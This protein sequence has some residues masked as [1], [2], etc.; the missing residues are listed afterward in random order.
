V[1]CDNGEWHRTR[2]ITTPQGAGGVPCPDTNETEICAMEA[3]P[4]PQD[5]LHSEWSAWSPC[6]LTCGLGQQV[7][8][9]EVRVEAANG[10]SPCGALMQEQSC[11]DRACPVDCQ[12]SSWSNWTAC[13]KSC[14]DGAIK[15]RHRYVVTNHEYNGVQ[16]SHEQDVSTCA[17]EAC[18][19][20]CIMS[21]FGDRSDCS[22]TCGDG[23]QTSS[24]ETLLNASYGGVACG[25][26]IESHTCQG[27]SEC[28]VDCSMSGW[29]NWSECTRTC[30]TGYTMR[31]RTVLTQAAEGG[32]QCP[33][34]TETIDC[35]TV[36]C[37]IDCIAGAW[38]TFQ[39]CTA[40]C[41]SGT[42]T[43]TKIVSQHPAHGGSVC[44]AVF[45]EL[46]CNPEPCAEDC[47]VGDWTEFTPCSRTCGEGHKA[48]TRQ[49]EVMPESGGVVCPELS[50]DVSCNPDPCPV[51]CEL[52]A[53]GQYADC[54]VTCGPGVRKRTRAVSVTPMNGGVDCPATEEIAECDEGICP[55]H[56]AVTAWTQW[57]GCHMTCGSSQRS[58]TREVTYHANSGLYSCP[59][60]AE[61]DSCGLPACPVDCTVGSWTGW[62]E[63]S[64]TCSGGKKA[65]SREISVESRDGGMCPPLTQEEQ[66]NQHVPC[67]GNCVLGDWSPYSGCTST[68]GSGTKYRTREVLEMP[69]YG[70]CPA[71]SVTSDCGNAACPTDCAVSGWSDW[72]KCG[73][74]ENRPCG[75]GKF[76]QVLTMVTNGGTPCPELADWEDCAFSECAAAN[77]ANNNGPD[78]C[79]HVTCNYHIANTGHSTIRVNHNGDE[80]NGDWHHCKRVD[81]ICSCACH[82]RPVSE[83]NE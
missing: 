38:G 3:C 44:P 23:T 30:D 36:L 29:G 71:L 48:R 17:T 28:P 12:M 1:T 20:D 5:C 57:S 40:T 61:S 49:V 9:R 46:T 70:A 80:E 66:C 25:N 35:G 64:M 41:G 55:S 2:E 26:S 79:S 54:S 67:P 78:G 62:S 33:S 75:K 59:H 50:E 68:C 13:T 83:T 77:P 52:A 82:D 47:D 24:R 11:D 16:C 63:C 22:V 4:A 18:P 74:T 15:R 7:R 27:N 8:E 56:C 43:R 14:G 37:P 39:D 81:G 73:I 32:V 10:G 42:Q 58:R 69:D 34:I 19:V 76:R 60:L 45:E 65:R 53:W 51:D 31:E 21:D 72:T 6:S